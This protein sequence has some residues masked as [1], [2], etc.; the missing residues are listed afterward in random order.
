MGAPNFALCNKDNAGLTQYFFL[1]LKVQ[2]GIYESFLLLSYK[3]I[4]DH[5]VVYLSGFVLEISRVFCH[6]LKYIECCI[7]KLP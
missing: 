3:M 7:L 2:T 1:K 6:N 5:S 4:D